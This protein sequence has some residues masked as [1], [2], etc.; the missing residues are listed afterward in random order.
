MQVQVS[1]EIDY[2]QGHPHILQVARGQIHEYVRQQ[3]PTYCANL[4][5]TTTTTTTTGTTGHAAFNYSHNVEALMN[6]EMERH[7]ME[8]KVR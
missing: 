8:D 1:V 5:P 3:G 7:L 4:S 2:D 6:L